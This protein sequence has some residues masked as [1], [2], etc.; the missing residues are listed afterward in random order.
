MAQ[1]ISDLYYEMMYGA[2]EDLYSNSTMLLECLQLTC[3]DDMSA[4]TLRLVYLK[5]MNSIDT[6]K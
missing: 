3:D 2:A 5:L 4:A 6:N 1:G